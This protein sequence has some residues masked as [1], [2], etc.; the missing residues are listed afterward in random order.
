VKP[1]RVT[2]HE[3]EIW[4]TGKGQGP[5]AV[6][7]DSVSEHSVQSPV[8]ETQ[9]TNEEKAEEEGNMQDTEGEVLMEPSEVEVS[10]N[11]VPWID[12]QDIEGQV[13]KI[14]ISHDAAYATAVAIAPEM[15]ELESVATETGAPP[16]DV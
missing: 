12:L 3:V 7:L 13:M 8:Q 4:T 16:S 6:I 1:R 11:A 5:I 2:L 14:S 9:V 10:R 15:P